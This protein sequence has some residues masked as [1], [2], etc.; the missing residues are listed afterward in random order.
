MAGVFVAQM[1]AHTWRVAVTGATDGVC[2]WSA[3]EVHA[4]SGNSTQLPNFEHDGVLDDIHAPASY[5][6]H[7]VRHL[8]AQ[9]LAQLA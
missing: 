7:L 6:S 1:A 9:A 3:A 5:R 2:R 8:Y 4:S